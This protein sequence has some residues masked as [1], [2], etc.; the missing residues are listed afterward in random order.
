MPLMRMLRRWRG[1]TLIELLVVIAIIAILIGL[2]LP[3]VQKVREAAARSQCSNNLKQISLGT[4]NC[5]DSNGSKLPPSVGLYPQLTAAPNNSDGGTFLHIL[6]YIEQQGLFNS[7][8]FPAGQT[9]D[10]RNGNFAVYTQWSGGVQNIVV[11]T[12]ACPSDPTMNTTAS[13]YGGGGPPGNGG[14]GSY[15]INGQVF[16]YGYGWG[17]AFTSYP[18]QITDGT[19]YTIFY[20]EKLSHLF[21]CTGC[22][23]DYDNNYWP[24]WGPIIASGDCGQPTGT[25]AMFQI[26]CRGDPS[27]CDGNRASSPHPN[28]INVGMADGSV[29]Y[30]NVNVNPNT[31]WAAMT[32]SNGEVLGNNW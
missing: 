17:P 8:Y 22:C 14:T 11:K 18:S 12:Y 27:N 3:A 16:R 32:P 24:D 19:A 23:N 15:G 26:G 7:T 6:P 28:G 31:W 5:S 20:T 4:V 10:G 21:G 29:R 1:F 30:V 25:A 2:L 9:Q 13:G